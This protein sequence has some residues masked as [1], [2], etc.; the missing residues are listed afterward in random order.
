MRP[1]KNQPLNELRKKTPISSHR[2]SDR[3]RYIKT[4]KEVLS[5]MEKTLLNNF[6]TENRELLKKL[7]EL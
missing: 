3:H 5:P 4:D 1:G 6:I 2:V 7:S